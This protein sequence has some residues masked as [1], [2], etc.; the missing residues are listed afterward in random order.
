M[1]TPVG[2]EQFDNYEG[3]LSVPNLRGMVKR[4]VHLH[5]QAWDRHGNPIDEVVHGLKAGTYQHEVDHLNGKI[6]VDRAPIRR[7]FT[8][9]TEFERHHRAAFVEQVTAAGRPRRLVTVRRAA[10]CSPGPAVRF[11]RWRWR[12]SAATQDRSR[13][14][15]EPRRRSARSRGKKK[16]PQPLINV[17]HMTRRDIN[18]VWDFLKVSFRDVNAET[19]E[20]QRPRSQASLRGGLRRG[21]HRAAACSRSTARSSRTPS[22]ATRS[23]ARDNWI[24][25]RYF[26]K[27]DMQPLFVDE[28]AVHPEMHGRGVG[29][30]VL[31]QLHHLAR[32]HGLNHLVLEVAEN[33][34]RAL[35]WYK[36][37]SFKKLDA[38]IFMACPVEIEPELL[39]PRELPPARDEAAADEPARATERRVTALRMTPG[40]LPRTE[41]RYRRRP[42]RAASRS[43]R[44]PERGV[45]ARGPSRA[46]CAELGNRASNAASLSRAAGSCSRHSASISI[47]AA[48][49]ASW[50][51]PAAS[52]A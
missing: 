24:N 51:L 25:P 17:R 45:A 39:P 22:A 52:A 9:W 10:A 1:L 41:S 49:S 8:T 31:E 50:P 19:V 33:N 27:R 34:E 32:V 13:R 3:C 4:F 42:R 21:G 23:P 40:E 12:A 2:D 48:S 15:A 38:A 37:R 14:D 5:V 28:L 29:S 6:F 46:R 47:A 7:T 18:R 30:F 43:Q 35:D 36:K 26:E 44:E 16:P 11:A 20:Y